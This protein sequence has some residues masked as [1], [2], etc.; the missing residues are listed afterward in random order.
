MMKKDFMFRESIESIMNAARQ[1]YQT[2]HPI[3]HSPVLDNPNLSG[4]R[5]PDQTG[6]QEYGGIA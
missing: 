6:S 2:I 5:Q 4:S 3:E 1:V